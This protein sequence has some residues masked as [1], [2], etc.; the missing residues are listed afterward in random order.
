MSLNKRYLPELDVLLERRKRYETDD[1]FLNA[2]VGKA[3]VIM[4]SCESVDYIDALYEE[5]QKKSNNG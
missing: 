1:E 4:G 3:D 2:V 5:I